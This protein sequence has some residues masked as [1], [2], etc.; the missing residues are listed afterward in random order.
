VTVSL[1]RPL[2]GAR[3]AWRARR[4]LRR[5]AGA[6]ACLALLAA[7]LAAQ[8]TALVL[9]GDPAYRDLDR[10]AALGML[11]TVVMGHRPYSRREI[12]RLASAAERS[13]RRRAGNG[14]ARGSDEVAELVRA[15]SR[16]FASD[17]A[18]AP[19][20]AVLAPFDGGAAGYTGSS[21][22]RRALVGEGR[23]IEATIGAFGDRR[24]GRPE[25]RGHGAWLEM[26]H[27][28]EPAPFLAGTARERVELRA[29]RDAGVA[30][31][32]AELLVA[33]VRARA[34]NVALTAGRSPVAWSQET[35]T[36]LL[37]A[38]DAPALDMISVSGERP[39]V[40][41]GF[42]RR[43]GAVQGTLLLA[44]LGASAVR[45]HSRLLAYKLSVAPSPRVEIGGSFT[46]RFGGEGARPAS[47]G[48]RLIDFLPFVDIFRRHNYTDTSRTLEVESDKMLGLDGRLRLP[49]VV[50]SGELVVDDFDVHRI[51]T[52]LTWDGSQSLRITVPRLARDDLALG[53]SAIHTGIRAY[54]HYQ[55]SA[56]HA[57]RGRLLGDELGPDAK[58]FGAELAWRP[59]YG[60]TLSLAARS[61]IHSR[62]EY[63]YVVDG[64]FFALRRVTAASN[65]LRDRLVVAASTRPRDDMLLAVRLGALRTRN[66]AFT[67]AT[68]RDGL[69]EVSL[70]VTR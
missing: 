7:P 14:A 47:V 3:R 35:G 9:P 60:T 4:A 24:L 32:D 36:G 21:V 53:L 5:A 45:S 31:G 2:A 20:S 1:D 50:L 59:R 62:A 67:G 68:R 23:E 39:W 10:L 18:T 61:A 6:V 51:P 38:S 25:V 34:G 46:S 70:L 69:A 22:Q 52:L 63:Q 43:A 26:A 33:S 48:D 64:S 19:R 37:F 16:R 15:L 27:R 57:S 29:P 55:L 40:L 28:V 30:G 11:D 54:Q 58:A 56:G 17:G 49:G 41:P 65:E 13:V 12:A 8:G 42:L 44:D 66:H